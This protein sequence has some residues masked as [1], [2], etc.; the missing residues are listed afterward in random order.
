MNAVSSVSALALM[1]AAAS[2][3]PATTF[4]QSSSFSASSKS[5]SDAILAA[6][7][8]PDLARFFN[9][10]NSKAMAKQV[11]QGISLNNSRHI[12]LFETIMANRDRFPSEEFFIH[13]ELEGGASITTRIPALGSEA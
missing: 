4:V 11:N 12:A 3:S 7:S 8:K 2:R 13:T 9:E 10:A 6:L 5:V 1:R